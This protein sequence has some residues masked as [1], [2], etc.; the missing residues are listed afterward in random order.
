MKARG[1]SPETI[2]P[3]EVSGFFLGRLHSLLKHV[4]SPLSK[5]DYL[6]ACIAIRDGKVEKNNNIQFQLE[7]IIHLIGEIEMSAVKNEKVEEKDIEIDD[8][9]INES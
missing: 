2:I 5:E 1:I 4:A 6:K 3:I 9:K 8:S 7:T